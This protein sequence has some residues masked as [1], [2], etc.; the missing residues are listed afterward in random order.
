MKTETEIDEI[1]QKMFDKLEPSGW[2]KVFKSF[3]FSSEFTDILSKLYE[4]SVADKRF[5]PTLKQLFRAFE[6]CPYDD[7]KVVF[8]G[9]DPYP[10]IGVADG[11]SFS[12]GNT[13][14]VQ[15][16]L[17][18]IFG[19]IE[20]TVYQEFPSYQDPDLTRWS[21]Q[22]ILMLNTALTVEVGK[23][24]S[25]YDIWKPFTAYVLD[26]LNNYNPGLVYVYMGK[27]AEEWS[28]L[29]GDNN[30]KFTVKHPAS[31]AYNGSKWDSND[32]FN[33]I[34]KLVEENNGQKIIW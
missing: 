22:G 17:R 33:K 23:I 34:S 12:C 10:Q 26:L 7:L 4:L 21:K 19:E 8:I 2:D 5:T 24:G 11:I 32:I 9:Q 31:A 16:S 13:N 25:H 27:K 28:E 30:H 18:Y 3:I 29:T 1:K 20:R 14:K 15:P 6:E